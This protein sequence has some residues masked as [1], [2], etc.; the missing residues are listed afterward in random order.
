MSNKNQ[1]AWS[2]ACGGAI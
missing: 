1:R 2:A